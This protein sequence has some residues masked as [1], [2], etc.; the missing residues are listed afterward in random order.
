ME[1]RAG[2]VLATARA[3]PDI[4]GLGALENLAVRVPMILHRAP[5]SAAVNLLGGAFLVAVLDYPTGDA[6][7]CLE[8]TVATRHMDVARTAVDA[9]GAKHHQVDLHTDSSPVER[10]RVAR[11]TATQRATSA[12]SPASPP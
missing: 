4:P 1:R 3:E 10:R 7:L 6:R 5:A 9:T 8:V 2:L 11:G 12:P